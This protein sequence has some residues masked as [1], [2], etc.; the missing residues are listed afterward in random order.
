MYILLNYSIIQLFDKNIKNITNIMNV[1][2]VEWVRALKAIERI[3]F[4]PKTIAIV[5]ELLQ[6]LGNIKIDKETKNIINSAKL[7]TGDLGEIDIMWKEIGVYCE[8]DLDENCIEL[9]RRSIFVKNG[10]NQQRLVYTE[11]IA[12]DADLEEIVLAIL[13]AIQMNIKK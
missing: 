1:M 5:R 9:R 12:T 4:C 2:N 10:N 8:V 13:A 3:K 7:A 6:L 11:F